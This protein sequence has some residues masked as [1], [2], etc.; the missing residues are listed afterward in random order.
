[1]LVVG[2]TNNYSRER[3][4]LGGNM[5][6]VSTPTQ[7]IAWEKL[8]VRVRAHTRA[9]GACARVCSSVPSLFRS[10]CVFLY[11]VFV[12]FASVVG[13]RLGRGTF[14]QNVSLRLAHAILL[15]RVGLCRVGL[16]RVAS[17]RVASGRVGSGRRWE[18]TQPRT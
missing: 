5:D 9:C 1:M 4:R 2:D 3:L 15:G 14:S 13:S 8:R 18:H 17:D 10:F 6:L 7:R 16:G 11:F 12:F